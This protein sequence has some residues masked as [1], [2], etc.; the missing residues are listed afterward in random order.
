VA[1]PSQYPLKVDFGD[2]L[3]LLGFVY[4]TTHAARE[5]AVR[6]YWQALRP[7]TGICASIPSLSMPPVK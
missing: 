5:A 2:E 1:D 7:L 6:L 3:R 4:W